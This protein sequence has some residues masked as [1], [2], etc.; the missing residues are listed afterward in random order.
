MVR[1]L[2]A[3]C[4]AVAEVCAVAPAVARPVAEADARAIRTVVT[5]QLDAFASDDAERA[6]SYAAPAIRTMFGTPER[7]L[8]MVRASYPVVYRAASVTFLVPL[9]DGTEIVQAVHLTDA[10]GAFWLATYRLERQRDGAWRIK[11][12]DVQPASGKMV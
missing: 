9:R 7:F 6:F 10:D 11:G 3:F 12:C 5:A 8:A 4:L 1:P 2:A